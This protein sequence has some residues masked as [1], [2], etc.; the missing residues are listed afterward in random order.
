MRA[1]GWRDGDPRTEREIARRRGARG[2]AARGNGR[3]R[4]RRAGGDARRTRFVRAVLAVAVLVVHLGLVDHGGAAV[5]S[6]LVAEVGCALGGIDAPEGSARLTVDARSAAG[7]DAAEERE[8]R[9]ERDV[10]VKGSSHASRVVVW[11]AGQRRSGPSQRR[12][13]GLAARARG[14]TRRATT[15]RENLLAGGDAAWPLS[16]S[17]GHLRAWSHR[18]AVDRIDARDEEVRADAR[19]SRGDGAGRCRRV[20]RRPRRGPRRVLRC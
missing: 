11:P 7:G 18:S 9:E 4:D 12:R 8:R 20:R 3:V 1:R 17:T 5:A 15:S 13:V 10:R 2:G 19:A 14:L 6:E 16:T